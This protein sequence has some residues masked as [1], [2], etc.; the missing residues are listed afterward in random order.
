MLCC[1]AVDRKGQ[2]FVTPGVALHDF[3]FLGTGATSRRTGVFSLSACH[4]STAKAEAMLSI[5][6][7]NPARR[8]VCSFKDLKRP[9][10]WR[11]AYHSSSR[12]EGSS[13]SLFDLEK[14]C[15]GVGLVVHR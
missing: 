4:E 6:M 14:S 7:Y 5:K 8:Q 11:L 2:F 15:K 9:D 1:R 12:K 3:L 13:P 10:R